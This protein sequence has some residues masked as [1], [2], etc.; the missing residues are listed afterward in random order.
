MPAADVG[1]PRRAGVLTRC[2]GPDDCAM[3]Y[4]NFS[5]T[6]NSSAPVEASDRLSAG[7]SREGGKLEFVERSHTD[8]GPLPPLK[9]TVALNDEVATAGA[10]VLSAIQSAG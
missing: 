2:R 5:V 6:R 8:H 9:K 1:P 7:F 3:S 4:I 10:A